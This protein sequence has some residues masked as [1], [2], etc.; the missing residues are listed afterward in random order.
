MPRE[1]LPHRLVVLARARLAP[2]PTPLGH[3]VVPREQLA[4]VIQR[5][6]ISDLS[7]PDDRILLLEPH[8]L[9]TMPTTSP[10]AGWYTGLPLLPGNAVCPTDRLQCGRGSPQSPCSPRRDRGNGCKLDR[11][12][13][14]PVVHR[15]ET[16]YASEGKAGDGDGLAFRHI[17]RKTELEYRQGPVEQSEQGDVV[18]LVEVDDSHPASPEPRTIVSE[19]HRQVL[20]LGRV[21]LLR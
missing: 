4:Q 14:P 10:V 3:D 1:P 2:Q 15:I 13:D 11:C 12:D 5:H 21:Q 19:E 18:L 17:L 8:T 9:L 16:E 6:G 20:L 7:R